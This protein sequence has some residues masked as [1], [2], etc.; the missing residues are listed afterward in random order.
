MVYASAIK[1]P[2][3]ERARCATGLH[4]RRQMGQFHALLNPTLG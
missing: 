2:V 4:A 3:V 1:L